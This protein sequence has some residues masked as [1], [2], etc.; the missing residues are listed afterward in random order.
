MLL[1]RKDLPSMHQFSAF[2]ASQDAS[3]H[4]VTY[5]KVDRP[6]SRSGVVKRHASVARLTREAANL[7]VD[8]VNGG[9][10][11]VNLKKLSRSNF[12]QR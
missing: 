3:K 12:F 2:F 8:G 9:P 11:F 7:S 5:G 1:H 6:Y 4:K 10:Q